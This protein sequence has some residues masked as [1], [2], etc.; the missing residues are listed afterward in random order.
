VTDDHDSERLA[1]HVVGLLDADSRRSVE[2]HLAHCRRCQAEA[3]ELRSLNQALD[4]VPPEALLEGP[5]PNGDFLLQRTLSHVRKEHNPAPSVMQWGLVAAA[6]AGIAAAGVGGTLVGR[7]ITTTSPPALGPPTPTPAPGAFV[8][9]GSDPAT[10]VNMT[11]TITP[12]A[13]WVR[14]SAQVEGVPAGTQ[15]RIVVVDR[16][17][18]A[19]TAGSWVVSPAGE[20]DG[21]KLDGSALVAPADVASVRVQTL[22]GLDLVVASV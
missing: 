7:E 19:M 16:K 5:P 20:A 17:G 2:T 4:D 22:D 18:V 11:A 6:V 9:A 21:T 3:A 15:C 10:G 12:A 1:A 8:V 13:G 14:L